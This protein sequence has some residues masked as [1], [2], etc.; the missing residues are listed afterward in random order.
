M[1]F[2]TTPQ[3][4]ATI[5]HHTLFFTTPFCT[6]SHT[7]V[8]PGHRHSTSYNI[9]HHT[10]ERIYIFRSVDSYL[11][12]CV[13]L[14]VIGFVRVSVWS[15]HIPHHKCCIYVISRVQIAFHITTTRL[16]TT[17]NVFTSHIIP[18]HRTKRFCITPTF[19]SH[20]STHH[21]CTFHI[22]L[23]RSTP[24]PGHLMSQPLYSTS[25]ITLHCSLPPTFHTTTSRSTT[26]S[27]VHIS[28]HT[29]ITARFTP[30]H[31]PHHITPHLDFT[32]H[33]HI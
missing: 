30:H 7:V 15:G 22:T 18:S 14:C 26:Y 4:H 19:T 16:H 5:S 11:P 13:K 29:H 31:I 17:L 6:T 1:T 3:F 32:S 27:T 23:L 21:H 33:H 25:D 10:L 8:R 20:H 2:H 9:L 12:V 24:H 28:H